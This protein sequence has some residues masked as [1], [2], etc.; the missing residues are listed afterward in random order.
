MHRG[1]SLRARSQEFVVCPGLRVTTSLPFALPSSNLFRFS[2]MRFYTLSII[3]DWII[4]ARK[5]K[6]HKNGPNPQAKFLTCGKDRFCTFSVAPDGCKMRVGSIYT[7]TH[8]ILHRLS[9]P[10]VLRTGSKN[11]YSGRF[12]TSPEAPRSYSGGRCPVNKGLH[13]NPG[14]LP[15]TDKTDVPW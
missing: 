14:V 9:Q 10:A 8:F 1:G 11:D 7:T 2:K 5:C 13:L 6:V 4:K 3:Y 15:H 12:F